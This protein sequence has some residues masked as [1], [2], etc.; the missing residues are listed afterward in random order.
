MGWVVKCNVF[1]KKTRSEFD[2]ALNRTK[3][4]SNENKLKPCVLSL[5]PVD[6]G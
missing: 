1:V 3:K 4:K 2:I 5:E 6:T